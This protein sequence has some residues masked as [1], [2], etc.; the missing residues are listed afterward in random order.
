MP[1]GVLN[2]SGA[3]A[4]GA[5][6]LH[7]AAVLRHLRDAR[8]VV[9]VGDVD[10]ALRVPGHVG[11]TVER[12]GV[13]GRVAHF[14]LLAAIEVL[15]EIV[16]RF[17]LA[18]EHHRHVPLRVELDDHVRAF[19]G[20]PDVVVLVDAD[21]VRERRGVVVRPPLLDE[22][23][24]RIELEQLRRGRALGRADVAAAGEHEQ[25][26][27]GILRDADGLADGVARDDQRQHFFG[28]LELRRGFLELQPAWRARPAV[29]GSA[30]RAAR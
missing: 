29:P 30:R 11:R 20:H 28:D 13:A 17:G 4:A 15:L 8:V 12:A 3:G 5:D 1:C 27:L 22:L 23:Q 9:A 26:P 24:V 18:A 16:D 6:R 19:V 14:V 25:V 21:G 2:W 10:V 7:P